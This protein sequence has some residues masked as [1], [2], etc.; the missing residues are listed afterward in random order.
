MLENALAASVQ[1]HLE[2]KQR[3]RGLDE[4]SSVE[5]FLAL[6]AVGGECPDDFDVL[7]EDAG[8][9]AMFGYEPPSPAAARKFLRQFHDR[10]KIGQAQPQQLDLQRA[11]VLPAESEA[12]AGLAA[13]N[14]D[15]VGKLGRRRADQKIAAVDLEATII[16]SHKRQA[17]PAGQGAKGYQPLLALWAEM[18]AVLGRSVSRRQH[19]GDPGAAGGGAAGVGGPARDG[20]RVSFSR[21]RGLL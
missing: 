7:R 16:V 14:R 2:L 6:N 4:A 17:R 19:T 15:V 1:R 21:R 20:G 10:E 13:L 18:D 3:R 5:S 9:A 8:M 11:S 12:L